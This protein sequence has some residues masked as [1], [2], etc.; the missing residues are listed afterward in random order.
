MH[1]PGEAGARTRR[2]RERANNASFC[3]AP[4]TYLWR[5]RVNTE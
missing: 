2:E 1:D 3:P 4:V 5:L